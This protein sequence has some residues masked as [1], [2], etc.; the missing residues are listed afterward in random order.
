MKYEYVILAI[1]AT[2]GIAF[3]VGG[4]AIFIHTVRTAAPVVTA[5]AVAAAPAPAKHK[6]TTWIHVFGCP[7]TTESTMGQQ[8]VVLVFDDG[9]TARL[10][11][12]N[13][14]SQEELDALMKFIGDASGYNIIAKCGTTT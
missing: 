8:D 9:T 14:F 7:A 2:V 11:N 4:G 6:L 10:P 12:L 5:P 3:I 13:K 1:V